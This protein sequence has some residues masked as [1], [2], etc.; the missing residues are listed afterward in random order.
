MLMWD[1]LLFPSLIR[2]LT[3]LTEDPEQ[4]YPSDD[5]VWAR[6][7]D[8]F[9]V[10]SGLITYAPVFT[11]YLYQSLEEFYADNVMYL[12]IRSGLT[13]VSTLRLINNFS[14][15]KAIHSFF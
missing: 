4:A 14:S 10:I 2:N 12:E 5:A 9:R 3:L 8:A 6:F 11:D 7:E 15:R 13:K 1:G